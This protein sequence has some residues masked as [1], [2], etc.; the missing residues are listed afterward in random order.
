M[1]KKFTKEF[2]KINKDLL[3]FQ[4]LIYVSEHQ[5]KDIIWIYHDKS[6]RKHHEIHKIIEAIFW[7]YY[8]LHMQ[9]KVKK[10]MNKCDLCHKIKLSRHRS[11]KEIRQTLTSDWFWTSIVMNFIVKLLF[12]KKLLTEVFYDLILMIVNWLIK[13][14]WFIS[15]KKVLNTEELAYTFLRN[16]TTL[17]DL[18]DEII[19]NKD[20]LFM[21]NF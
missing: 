9:E 10:Y 6:L 7:S 18:S 8:F 21:S 5:Q 11:Y 19:F 1:L 14:V 17:Q 20:K 16:V 13:E 4:E 3:L 15:Y 12:S 2:E